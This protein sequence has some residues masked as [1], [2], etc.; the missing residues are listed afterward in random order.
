[1]RV[2]RTLRELRQSAIP[3][4]DSSGD[5]EARLAVMKLARIAEAKEARIHHAERLKPFVGRLMLVTDFGRLA[6]TEH[7]ERVAQ[8]IRSAEIFR[9]DTRIGI[10]AH[11]MHERRLANGHQ[12]QMETAELLAASLQVNAFQNILPVTTERDSLDF[13]L[14][15]VVLA[16]EN[17][18]R[19]TNAL[20][21]EIGH[22]AIVDAMD[23][24]QVDIAGLP[25][26]AAF[27]LADASEEAQFRWQTLSANP[28]EV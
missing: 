5:I 22:I 8:D 12:Q 1:M 9:P 3:E 17:T 14:R 4:L 28:F 7:A 13:W 2:P 24:R 20:P 27:I 18:T 21:C 15:T 23:V 26:A 25:D 10:S 6:Q 16:A 11:L 19:A